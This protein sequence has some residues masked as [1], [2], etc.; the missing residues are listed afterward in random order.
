MS[1]LMRGFAI[2]GGAVCLSL[3]TVSYAASESKLDCA[4]Q[5]Y[6]MSLKYQQSAEIEALQYQA[7]QLA[8]YRLKEVLRQHPHAKNLA[9]VTDLDETVLDNSAL[10]VSD[11]K[12]CLDFTQWNSWE[13]WEQNGRPK[14]IAGSLA[15]FKFANQHGI[16]IYYVSDRSEQ[17]RK[18]TLTELKRLGLPQVRSEQVLLY[19]TS[20]EQ[21]RQLIA[22]KHKIVLLLGDTLHDFSKNFNQQ[23]SKLEKQKRITEQRQHFGKDWIVLP[24]SS[25]GAWSEDPLDSSDQP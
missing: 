5:Q 8:T 7:Y 24:N 23:L 13:N 6:T 20:K 16:T 22:K 11:V 25:Y 1:N 18:A 12:Q 10:F 9:V 15:F 4:A 14:L 2:V 17:N 3:T 19:G 21:R